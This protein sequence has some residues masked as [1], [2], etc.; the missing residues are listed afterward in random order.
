M[1]YPSEIHK[2]ESSDC[3]GGKKKGGSEGGGEGGRLYSRHY[4][5]GKTRH[6]NLVFVTVSSGFA[7]ANDGF[8][9]NES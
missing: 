3:G 4:S 1:R 8:V 2:W 7:F 9:V 6:T 5:I